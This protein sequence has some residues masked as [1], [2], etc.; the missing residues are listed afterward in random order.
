MYILSASSL[1]TFSLTI[2]TSIFMVPL[3]N[4]VSITS[5]TFTSSPGTATLP[6]IVTLPCSQASFAI[7]L[8]LIILAFLRYLSILIIIHPFQSQIQQIHLLRTSIYPVGYCPGVPVGPSLTW[9]WDSLPFCPMSTSELQ[10]KRTAKCALSNVG[11][12][13]VNVAFDLQP[14]FAPQDSIEECLGYI[15]TL[16]FDVLNHK[17]KN[18]VLNLIFLF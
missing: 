8:L 7:V 6:L 3:P 17:Q 12:N 10:T 13:N 2:V 14:I 4:L 15:S 16:S 1:L 18:Q 5:E 11:V 9:I